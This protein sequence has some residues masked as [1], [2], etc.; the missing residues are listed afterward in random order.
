MLAVEG[1]GISVQIH[2][3][4]IGGATIRFISVDELEEAAAFRELDLQKRFRYSKTALVAK[5]R[6]T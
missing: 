4:K 2:F 1:E 6:C 3:T 5:V